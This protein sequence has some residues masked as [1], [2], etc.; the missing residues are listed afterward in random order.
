MI[1]PARIACFDCGSVTRLNVRQG[2]APRSRPASSRARIY[3]VELSEERQDHVWDVAIDETH[4]HRDGA[5][6]EPVH[7]RSDGVDEDQSLVDEAVVLQQPLPCIDA[8]QVADPE[9]RDEQDEE[10]ALAPAAIPGDVVRDRVPEDQAD[11]ARDGN[12]DECPEERRP[13]E[14]RVTR[15]RETMKRVDERRS[16]PVPGLIDGERVLEEIGGPERDRHH[17]VE[18]NDEQHEEPD[19]GGRGEGGPIQPR[20]VDTGVPLDARCLR[21]LDRRSLGCGGL[22]SHRP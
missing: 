10:Q 16:A 21:P 14:A 13:I 20:E 8:H 12:I 5:P 7:R 1:S 3:A 6:L 19:R 22:A 2:L 15:G 18:R 17:H 11:E 9:R 4:D